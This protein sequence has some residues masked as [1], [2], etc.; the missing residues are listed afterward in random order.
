MPHFFMAQLQIDAGKLFPLLILFSHC[1]YYC[2]RV[3]YEGLAT[4]I[5]S[6]L[7]MRT[8]SKFLQKLF[9]SELMQ[10][11]AFCGEKFWWMFKGAC[12]QCLLRVEAKH[13]LILQKAF[14]VLLTFQIML[15]RQHLRFI[16]MWEYHEIF[17]QY[18]C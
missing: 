3:A 5:P 18:L 13:E 11:T 9:S 1:F 7:D 16:L 2:E 6:R 14:A 17:L 10:S 4:R 15:V 8:N 12:K